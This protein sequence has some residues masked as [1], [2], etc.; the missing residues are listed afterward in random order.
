MRYN[1]IPQPVSS[2]FRGPRGRTRAVL[3]SVSHGVAGLLATVPAP[4]KKTRPVRPAA[5]VIHYE[6][7]TNSRMAG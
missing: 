7:A 5:P 3:S 1:S 6:I 2:L 4:K